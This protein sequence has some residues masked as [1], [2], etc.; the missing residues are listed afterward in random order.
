[1][2]TYTWVSDWLLLVA[3][4]KVIAPFHKVI[5]LLTDCLCTSVDEQLFS[6]GSL[7]LCSLRTPL[8][9]KKLITPLNNNTD[10]IWYEE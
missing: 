2:Q 7:E 3:I 9:D 4:G 5:Y 6:N 1:M 10:L 8:Q